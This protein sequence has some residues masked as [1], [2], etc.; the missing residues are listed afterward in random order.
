MSG[1]CINCGA[2]NVFDVDMT[3][4][5]ATP[6]DEARFVEAGLWEL[7]VRMRAEI[8]RRGRFGKKKP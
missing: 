1:L 7:I 3:L 4:R 6:A 2:V 5:R 8:L